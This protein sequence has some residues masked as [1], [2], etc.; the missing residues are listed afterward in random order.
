MRFLGASRAKVSNAGIFVVAYIPQGIVA[1]F[2]MID[3]FAGGRLQ[4][5]TTVN[6]KANSCI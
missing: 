2:A 5:R 1:K 6:S 3:C 4:Q